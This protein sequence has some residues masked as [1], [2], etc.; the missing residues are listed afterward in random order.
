[1]KCFSSQKQNTDTKRQETTTRT[2]QNSHNNNKNNNNNN[3]NNDH[4]DDDDDDEECPPNNVALADA[5]KELSKLHQKMPLNDDDTWKAYALD[6]IA[7]RI[8]LLNFQ[9]TLERESQEL[10]KHLPGIGLGTIEKINEFL[11]TGQL[12]RTREF[13]NDPDRVAMKHMMAIWGVGRSTALYQLVR[14][15]YRTIDDVR[16]GLTNNKLSLNRNQR[17]GVDCWEDFQEQMTREEVETI[18]QIIREAVRAEFPNEENKLEITIMGSYR[19]GATACGDADILITH[20]DYVNEIPPHVLGQV[21]EKLMD[22]GHM[23]YHLTFISGMKVRGKHDYNNGGFHNQGTDI[24]PKPKADKDSG[25]SYM[26]V[27]R[28]PLVKGRRRRVDIKFYPYRA[29]AFCWLY[30]TGNGFF[31]RS[32]R[33]WAA[34][35]HDLQMNDQGLFERGLYNRGIK[36]SVLETSEEREVFKFLGLQY[37]EPPERDCFDAVIF[38]DKEKE[39]NLTREEKKEEMGHKWIE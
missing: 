38:D 11:R 21:V 23:A 28:S 13:Q 5:L 6:K 14:K 12:S 32:M 26:G 9:V 31:N 8:R 33:L 16:N 3:N 36:K 27:F 17:I 22:A 19:R 37:K 10:L 4:D 25:A 2:E 35:K 39:D 29:R 7:G 20:R 30:F 24:P 15:G 1:L 34:R 18:G